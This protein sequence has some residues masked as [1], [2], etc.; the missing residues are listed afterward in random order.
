[1][2]ALGRDIAERI[3]A[4][5]PISVA[6][7]MTLCLSHPVHGYYTAREPFGPDGDFTTAPEISQMFG[8][9]LG[10]WTADIWA[11]MGAPS[12]VRLVEL[13]PGRGTLMADAMRVLARVPGWADAASLHLVETSP[14]LR[15]RQARAL[16]AARPVWHDRIEDLPG[17]PLILLANEFLDALPIR[18]VERTAEGWRERL[19]GLQNGAL[20]FQLSPEPLDALDLPARLRAAPLGSPFEVS[21]ARSAVAAWIGRRVAR[22]GGAALLIDYGHGVSAPGDTF[23]AVRAHAFADPLQSPGLAD[24]TAHV[25]FEALAR[26]ATQAGAAAHGPIA[27]GAFLEA[28]GIE[29]RAARLRARA[30]DELRPAIAAALHRLTSADAMGTLFKV[31]AI[32]AP[33]L[34]PA[35]FD[36]VKDLGKGQG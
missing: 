3:A 6:E 22:E 23:Q 16:G 14:R 32:C 31:M 4:S 20:A 7:Y 1:M 19:V 36:L 29:A 27:Q 5:G 17:G 33:S 2:T 26:A 15:D 11:R 35:P 24:L 10:A 18:Q 28:L 25:D 34:T 9:L 21:P 12:P 30:R 8:E 13:G